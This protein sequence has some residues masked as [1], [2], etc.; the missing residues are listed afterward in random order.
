MKAKTLEVAKSLAKIKSL[1]D[2]HKGEVIHIIYC[3]RTQ[4]FYIDING[5]IRS[6]EQQ[7]GYY[8]DGVYTSEKSHL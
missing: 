7:F 2:E 4:F 6:W 8:I 5:L 1:E 3:N